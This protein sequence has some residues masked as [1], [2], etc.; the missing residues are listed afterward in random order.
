MLRI[1]VWESP[2]SFV[3]SFLFFVLFSH[4]S[5]S[6]VCTEEVRMQG[7]GILGSASNIRTKKVKPFSFKS[8]SG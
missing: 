8:A 7:S 2:V 6:P 1:P 3:T 5:L 4:P